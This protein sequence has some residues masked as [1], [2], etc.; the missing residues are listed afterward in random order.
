MSQRFYT[1]FPASCSDIFYAETAPS[2]TVGAQGP[3]CLLLFLTL[4]GGGVALRLA[5][6]R[7]SRST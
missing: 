5:V 6:T 7:W 4:G 3:L 1:Y 2:F